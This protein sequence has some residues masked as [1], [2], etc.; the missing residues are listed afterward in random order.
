VVSQHLVGELTDAE[1]IFGAM[2]RRYLQTYDAVWQAKRQGKAKAPDMSRTIR[3]RIESGLAGTRIETL[4]ESSPS[5]RLSREFKS[6]CR[7]LDR[8]GP[9][10]ET[11]PLPTPPPKFRF[12]CF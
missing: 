4:F 5:S 1:Q 11:D 7:R 9:K 8:I 6:V 2:K 10:A 12:S 3:L